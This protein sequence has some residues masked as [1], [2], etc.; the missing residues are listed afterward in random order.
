MDKKI[1][2]ATLRNARQNK[3]LTQKEIAAKLNIVPSAYSRLEKGDRDLRIEQLYII[4]EVLGESITEFLIEEKKHPM[5]N[6]MRN[7]K[8]IKNETELLESI[9]CLLGTGIEDML[10]HTFNRFANQLSSIPYPFEEYIEGEHPYACPDYAVRQIK[11]LIKEY[12]EFKSDPISWHKNNYFPIGIT[13]DADG[14]IVEDEIVP[15]DYENEMYFSHF[16]GRKQYD[17]FKDKDDKFLKDFVSAE[18]N[19]NF[20][21]FGILNGVEYIKEEDMYN[22]FK[23][24]LNA[25]PMAITLFQFGLL[26]E[27]W[28]KQYWKQY[29]REK[30]PISMRMEAK[31]EGLA[32]KQIRKKLRDIFIR[33]SRRDFHLIPAGAIPYNPSKI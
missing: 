29:L 33:N 17:Y 1:N 21:H 27:S 16:F 23:D 9:I 6:K 14:K 30:K 3:G 5:E 26:E 28:F 32:I 25:E 18:E 11:K 15:K 2:Y 19:Y 13:R 31:Q 7:K 4:A 24:M 8:R 20:I 12:E 22:A 10:L